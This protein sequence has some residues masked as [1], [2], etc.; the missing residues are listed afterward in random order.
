MNTTTTNRRSRRLRGVALLAAAGLVLGACA[1]DAGDGV[2]S[3]VPEETPDTAPLE[4]LGEEDG[5]E[6]TEMQETETTEMQETETT[7]AGS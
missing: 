5:T 6:T 2:D 3:V 7:E 4:D 1:D